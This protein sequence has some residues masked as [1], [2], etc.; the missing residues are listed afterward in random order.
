M[1]KCSNH[2]LLLTACINPGGMSFTAINNAELRKKQY[3]DA[4]TFYL[5]STSFSIVFVE[6]YEYRL[7]R[8]IYSCD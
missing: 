4:L 3:I 2:I 6:K 5:Q 7:K 1:K 8:F